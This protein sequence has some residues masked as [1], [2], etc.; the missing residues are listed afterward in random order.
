[1]QELPFGLHDP[2][3]RVGMR[4]YDQSGNGVTGCM[5]VKGHPSDTKMIEKLDD[6][7]QKEY[8]VNHRGW[9]NGKPVTW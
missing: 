9:R 2:H 4:C 5:R 1:M 6:N 3:D 7:K 8:I